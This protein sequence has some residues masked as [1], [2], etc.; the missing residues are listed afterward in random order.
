ME[1][2]DLNQKSVNLLG[3]GLMLVAIILGWCWF[4]WKLA[5]VIFLALWANNMERFKNS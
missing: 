3:A 5:L 1:N 2:K 4:G